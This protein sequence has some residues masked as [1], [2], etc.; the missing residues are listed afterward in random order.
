M[1]DVPS[2]IFGKQS[3]FGA[4]CEETT[5]VDQ[6][7]QLH[8]WAL[9]RKERVLRTA[10]CHAEVVSADAGG[11]IAAEWHELPAHIC[12]RYRE[13]FAAM[14]AQPSRLQ[15]AVRD[16]LREMG[17]EPQ[18]EVATPHGYSIDLVV[19]AGGRRVAVEVDGPSHFL[20]TS[21][22]A[23][24]ATK[25]KRRQLE[26]FGWRLLSVPY[27]EWSALK[28][29]RTEVASKGFRAYLRRGLE[30]VLGEASPRGVSRRR[31]PDIDP[32]TADSSETTAEMVGYSQERAPQKGGKA[33]TTVAKPAPASSE[34]TEENLDAIARRL[35]QRW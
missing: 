18:E 14:E 19:E 31:T 2:P 17:F 9:W 8:Q 28:H 21:R 26:A 7:C 4:I 23:T 24:G 32:R 6:M 5:E 1:A 3:S 11:E 29:S 27:W 35:S 12:S 30:E 25:L 13:A 15:L 16:A 33:G 10:A 20:G 34:M 22:M